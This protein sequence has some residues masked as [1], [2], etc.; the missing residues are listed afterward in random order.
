MEKIKVEILNRSE[1]SLPAYE[2]AGAAGMDLKAYVPVSF[3][4]QPGQRILVPTGV[5]VAIPEGYEIQIRSRSGMAYK[6]G[7][8]VLNS[9][10]TIDSDYR[11]EIKLLLLNTSDQAYQINDGD[12]LGQMVLKK[13]EQIEWVPVEKLSD[14]ERGA[15][16]FGSTGKS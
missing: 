10:G 12:R 2:T 6:H 15:G 8:I 9:P 16:G 11:G 3:N 7:V 5:F 14:T 13:V 4:L 1:H